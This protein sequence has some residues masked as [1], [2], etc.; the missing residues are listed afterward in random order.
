MSLRDYQG[1]AYAFKTFLLMPG[2]PAGPVSRWQRV[3]A[4]LRTW[5]R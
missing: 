2:P 1:A 3:I 4:W 5:G